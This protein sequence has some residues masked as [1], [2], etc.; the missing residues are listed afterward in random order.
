MKMTILIIDRVAARRE[1]LSLALARQGNDVR[2]ARDRTEAHKILKDG[3]KVT[4][5][6]LDPFCGGAS[7]NL[8]MEQV[9]AL[10]PAS[11]V[12]LLPDDACIAVDVEPSAPLHEEPEAGPPTAEL[13]EDSRWT[14]T[15]SN[16]A[17]LVAEDLLQRV[18]RSRAELVRVCQESLVLR[19]T[20]RR[21]RLRS[22]Q[23]V[24]WSAGGFIHGGI[25]TQF[26]PDGSVL[27]DESRLAGSGVYVAVQA[28]RVH[29]T[30]EDAR[31]QSQ[32]GGRQQSAV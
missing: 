11:K 32:A 27:I 6:L 31:A 26:L 29:M 7:A 16:V 19:T 21:N 15:Q 3:Y 23:R 28:V 8:F 14:A 25:F 13:R 2:I 22:G 30:L 5:I 4:L 1:R 20:S 17:M 9:G 10:A 18:E 12:F 24:W